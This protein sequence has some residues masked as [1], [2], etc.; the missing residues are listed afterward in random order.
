MK[1]NLHHLDAIVQSITPTVMAPCYGA[2]QGLEECGQRYIAA[3]DGLYL[4]VRRRWLHALWRVSSVRPAS[5]PY[6]AVTPAIRLL[7]G[8]PPKRFLARFKEAAR[9]AFPLETAA[10]ITWS[11]TTGH[12]LYR[13]P[14]MRSRTRAHV[15]YERPVLEEGEY[16]VVDM[17]SHGGYPAGFSAKDDADD[18]GEVKLSLVIGHCDQAQPSVAIR[19]SA[20]GHFLPLERLGRVDDMEVPR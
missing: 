11:A 8:K 16:L 18:R 15:A 3:R 10:W 19:L 7:C 6:G 1:A 14:E 2:L 20:L 13:T 4:E 17:H 9:E 5:L 12:F